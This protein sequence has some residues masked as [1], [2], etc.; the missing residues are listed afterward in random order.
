MRASKG[1]AQL[2][3][4]VRSSAYTIDEWWNPAEP[5]RQRLPASAYT[6]EAWFQREREELFAKTWNFV[7]MLEDVSDPGDYITVECGNAALVV[8]RDMT[9]R[10]RAF[11]NVCRHRGARLLEGSGNIKRGLI[12]CFYHKWTYNLKGELQLASVPY[13]Q[14]LFPCLDK[15]LYG[16]HH[17]KVATWKNLLF[18]HPDPRALSLEEWLAEIPAKLGPFKPNQERLHD[19]EELVEISDIT[20]RVRAN[21]KIVT[22]NFIDGYHLP[23]LHS[24]SLG[25][26]D[27]MQQRWQPSGRHQ[28]FY[29][30]LKPD[31]H[32]DRSYADRDEPMPV[33]EG[34]PA[35][36]G[37]SYQW[38]FPNIAVS[39]TAYTWSTFHVIAVSAGMSLV[40]TRVRATK[41]ATSAK[42][43]VVHPEKL[44]SHIV[45]AKGFNLSADRL[46]I[47]PVHALESNNVM[48]E[49]I[50]AC[51]K[52]QEGMASSVFSVGPLSK[53]EAPLSFFQSQIL[54]FV[55]LR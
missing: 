2:H 27:F 10:L 25:D 8:L 38:L 55:P 4:M 3:E 41:P 31:I 33:I 35:D 34:I 1:A 36:Y 14:E 15:S 7:G 9:G 22:E 44:P 49:D 29:R 13:Q 54:D 21:W 47:G 20:Y 32:K 16:L 18:V 26:G 43:N 39:Q 24:V 48:L 11:H 52:V 30:P 5:P 50:Y 23:L 46:E 28:A 51:E 45:S 37:F 40:R 19:P 17:A 53:W 6:S 42:M 12:S